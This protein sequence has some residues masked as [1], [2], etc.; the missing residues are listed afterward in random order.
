MLITISETRLAGV[1]K[2]SCE[3]HGKQIETTTPVKDYIKSTIEL[4]W[5]LKPRKCRERK[6][7]AENTKM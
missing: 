3:D 4:N 1:S 7:C 5:E 2:R 6:L